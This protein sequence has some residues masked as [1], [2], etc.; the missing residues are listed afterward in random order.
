MSISQLKNVTVNMIFML[1][2]DLSR[3][4]IRSFL[5]ASAKLFGS[6][7]GSGTRKQ[8]NFFFILVSSYV[9]ST[10]FHPVK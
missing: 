1:Y 3:S 6:G 10:V 5:S 9:F 7:F 4:R 8:N 2:I